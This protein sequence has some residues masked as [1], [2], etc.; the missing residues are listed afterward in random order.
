[1]KNIMRFGAVALW[2][3]TSASLHAQEAERT[4]P[5][6]QWSAYGLVNVGEAMGKMRFVEYGMRFGVTLPNA[7]Y[8]GGIFSAT[9]PEGYPSSSSFSPSRQFFSF[10][11]ELG[12]VLQ[13][14]SWWSGKPYLAT[15]MLFQ[16]T[17]SNAF[18]QGVPLSVSNQP[19]GTW[20]GYV[21][22]GFMVNFT[23]ASP[24]SFAADVKFEV[25]LIRPSA[26]LMVGFAF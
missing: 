25:P 7:V 19:T 18:V 10:G 11:A 23:P 5:K 8:I 20:I 26:S 3:M 2:V 15:G 1:M 13:W 16:E 9:P 14:S 21:A 12:Y 17:R 24:L 4:E 6:T 22:P